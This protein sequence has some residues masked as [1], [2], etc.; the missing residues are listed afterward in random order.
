L[1]FAEEIVEY[2][3]QTLHCIKYIELKSC[4]DFN[5]K[6][7]L[8][9]YLSSISYVAMMSRYQTE[10]VAIFT[11]A[12]KLIRKR[13]KRVNNIILLTECVLIIFPTPIAVQFTLFNPESLKND[14]SL[15]N[16]LCVS[17]VGL[18]LS[19]IFKSLAVDPS[20]TFF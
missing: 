19:W 17:I 8:Q 3:L 16:W 7:H 1:I 18:I 20:T 13:I 14:W 11:V 12:H 6:V 2:S 15:I 5:F 10:R 4:W 9:S